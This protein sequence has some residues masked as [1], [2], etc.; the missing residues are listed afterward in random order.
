MNKLSYFI[1]NV[2]GFGAYPTQTDIYELENNGFTC[3]I[4][5]TSRL[6]KGINSYITDKMKIKFPIRD[7]SAP[8]DTNSFLVFIQ[9]ICD[10]INAREKIY[11]HCK[12]GHGRSTLVVVS[13]MFF[14]YN[15]SLEEVMN[16]TSELH[17]ARTDLKSKYLPFR[18]H[19]TNKQRLFIK[20]ICTDA[21][22][23]HFCLVQ[24]SRRS[25]NLTSV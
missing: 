18:T 19:Q 13:L 3:F 17:N 24:D 4:D 12:G 11:I 25:T 5:L 20:K 16:R 15:M 1:E 21:T 6:E 22:R 10:L 23:A 14:M 2:V 8:F 7:N 9:Y